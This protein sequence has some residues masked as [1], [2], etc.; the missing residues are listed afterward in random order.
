MGSTDEALLNDYVLTWMA[1][2]FELT[3]YARYLRSS[4]AKLALLVLPDDGAEHY[5]KQ[6]QERVLQECQKEWQT[7]LALE[8]HPVM[9]NV[10]KKLCPH[11]RFRCL[12]EPLT[13]LEQH[14]FKMSDDVRE[15]ILAWHP[16]VSH[17]ANVEGVFNGLEDTVKRAMKSNN[18][19]LP[20]IQCSAIR[21]VHRKLCQGD[22]S[23]QGVALAPPDFEG[24]EIRNIRP[25]VFKPESFQGS[26]C[27]HSR[28]TFTVAC[29]LSGVLTLPNVENL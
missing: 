12:R 27:P 14:S 6:V 15:M 10:L 5:Q 25:N 8:E 17:S 9:N 11:T 23:P 16:K 22:A 26:T 4:P 18:P 21:A 28:K 1:A 19:S 7:I 20:N 13:C 24:Q 3:M 29:T 2:L